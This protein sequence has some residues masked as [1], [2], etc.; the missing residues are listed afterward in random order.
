MVPQ[1]AEV[2][3]YVRGSLVRSCGL[4]AESKASIKDHFSHEVSV[5]GKTA[6]ADWRSEL[7]LRHAVHWM[8]DAL[9]ALK[10]SRAARSSGWDQSP[11]S[12]VQPTAQT[13]R[14]LGYE[15]ESRTAPLHV[16]WRQG[17]NVWRRIA[18][19]GQ[20]A[21]K[22]PGLFTARVRHRRR[23]SRYHQRRAP[24]QFGRRDSLLKI[25]SAAT[26]R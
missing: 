5:D 22:R 1:G 3:V 8:Q 23:H 9:A 15:I 17:T 14:P 19:P 13:K 6:W 7:L 4:T 24:S 16:G 11:A 10:H 21:E 26:A 2:G 12:H 20:E 25:N 18:S